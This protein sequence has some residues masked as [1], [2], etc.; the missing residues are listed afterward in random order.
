MAT[1]PCALVSVDFPHSMQSLWSQP[2][3]QLAFLHIR[4]LQHFFHLNGPFFTDKISSAG[5]MH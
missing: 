4:H 3:P 1:C 5:V 2:G